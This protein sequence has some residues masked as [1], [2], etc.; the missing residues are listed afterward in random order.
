V[1]QVTLREKWKKMQE[2]Y[3]AKVAL[4]VCG[5]KSAIFA[6]KVCAAAMPTFNFLQRILQKLYILTKNVSSMIKMNKKGKDL[7]CK[8]SNLRARSIQK[9]IKKVQ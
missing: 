7:S 4:T 1:T 2:N 3:F 8:P 5:L 6:K 9:P